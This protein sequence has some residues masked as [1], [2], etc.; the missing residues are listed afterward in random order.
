SPCIKNLYFSNKKADSYSQKIK[1]LEAEIALLTN[2]STDTIYRLDYR[3]MKYDYISSAVEKLL[4]FTPQE[5]RKINF[6]SLILETRLVTD[7]LRTVSSF[8]ELEYKRKN[9]DV[10]KWQADYLISTKSGQKIWV[11]D[12]S[13]PWL[14]EK[15][16]RVIGSVGS[17]R[18][19]TDRVK[20]ENDLL[21]NFEKAGTLD[22]LTG[23]ISKQVFFNEVEYELKRI[24]R[25]KTEVS[26]VLIDIDGLA[27]LNHEIGSF[28]GDKAILRVTD[29]L[30]KSLRETD[31]IARIDG[32]TF[33]ALLPE[34]AVRTAFNVVERIRENISAAEIKL[35]GD[36]TGVKFNVSCGLASSSFIENITA[37][38]LYK[39]ADN[40]LSLAK[41]TGRSQVAI[42][43]ILS[44]H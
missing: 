36:N 43:E 5:M 19:I 24:K 35:G 11:S 39:L 44:L 16:G 37:T 28:F 25:N 2:Y 40:R 42:E 30:K 32:G 12:V 22:S 6:R 1:K 26:M 4:G 27:Q 10:G 13:L 33:A 7:G 23:L 15:S 18:D 34:T 8:D 38:D 31:I 20:M 9:G 21:S 29:N 41:R 3:T 14:D 17:L